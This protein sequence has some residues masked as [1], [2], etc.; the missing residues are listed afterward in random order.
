M[1]AA[2]ME[3]DWEWPEE[4]PMQSGYYNSAFGGV[5]PPPKK[6]AAAP[7]EDEDPSKRTT[8]VRN[9][10][11]SDDT[12]V[13]KVYV[14]V[15]GVVRDGV[16]VDIG[17]DHISMRAVTPE[18]GSFTMTINRLYDTVD[19]CKSSHK[20]LERKEKV[21]IT[22][23]KYPPPGYGS[24]A[25]IN[26]KPWYKLHHGGTNNIDMCEDLEQARLQRGVQMNAAAEKTP[27]VPEATRRR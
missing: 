12:N 16:S 10:S 15:P 3:T 7:L 21:I 4:K 13:I 8:Q 25:Y 9:Y 1:A 14:P 5:A 2:V 18:F 22:L 26:F 20:V 24:D 23:A 11:W 17:E 19:L 27:K 6:L